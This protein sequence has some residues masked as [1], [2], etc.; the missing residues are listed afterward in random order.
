MKIKVNYFLLALF[1]VYSLPV[2]SNDGLKQGLYFCSFEV[3]K[4]KRTCLDLTPEKPLVF[5]QGFS[6][7]F[8]LNLRN[9]S[10]TFG[11]VFRIVCNDTLNVDLLSNM[12]SDITSETSTFSLIIKNRNVI[13]YKKLEI[14]NT[15]ENIWIKIQFVFD[16]VA[17][18]ISLSLNGIK[19]EAPYTLAGLNHFNVYFG[20]NTHG[21][22]STTDIAPMT[23]KDIRLFNEKKETVR[24]WKLGKH[25]SDT[26]Y[27][28][29]VPDRATTHNPVWEIDRH[30]KWEKRGTVAFA[31]QN[32]QIAFDRN[33]SRFFFGGD[34]RILVFDLNQQKVDTIEVLAGL[35]F[36]IDLSNHLVYDPNRRVLLSYDFGN[37]RL[38]TFDFSTCRWNN[39]D[40]A[41]I[42]PRYSH[43]SQLFI[44]ADSLL[45]AFGGYGYHR[46]NSRFFKCRVI[47]NVWDMADLSQT[48]PPRYLGSMGSLDD[49][50]ML[51]FSGFGNESGRQEEFPK[52]YYDLYSINIENFDVKKIWELSNPAEHFTN[53]NSMVIDK[54]R[55]KFYALAYSNKRYESIIKLH[56]YS[57]DKPEYRIA[58]DSIPY[59]FNDVESYCN[60]FQSSDSSELFA[61]TSSVKNNFSEI[62]IYAIA[63]PALNP[64]ETIQYP[65]SQSGRW[66]LSLLVIPAALIAIFILFWKKRHKRS[67]SLE[68]ES[69][70]LYEESHEKELTS[71]NGSFFEERKHSYIRLLGKFQIINRTG[72]E[73]AKNF[74]PT[75]TQ[76][77]LLLLMSTIKNGQGITPQELRKIL[78]FDKDDESAR[79]NRNV[80][81][82]KLRSILKPFEEVAIK[83][84][85]GYFSIQFEKTVFCDYERALILINALKTNNS[86]NKNL[87]TELV[88]IALTGTLLPLIQQLEWI[89][90]YQSDYANQLIECLL[91]YSKHSEV[92]QDLFLL[93]KIADVIL[94]HDNTDEDAIQQKC[95]A[96]FHLGRKKQALQVFNKF[97]A[98][99]ENLLGSKHHLIFEELVKPF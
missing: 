32:Y 99:Y 30:A 18:C 46:Y 79:N 29:C 16:P 69:N 77:F 68:L 67:S 80:Y 8:D 6:M 50:T 75:T 3:N 82:N 88:D 23:V 42:M 86:N 34:K 39:D 44:A 36:N 5:R 85:N 84:K 31:G 43:H 2:K 90:P 96:L 81:I 78:W 22:F 13:Q 55:R 58:G 89:D 61:L 62:T 49:H 27:D 64:E 33:E 35:P 56:E 83:N 10:Q 19:K 87:L 38:A 60:L 93:S 63:F 12:A 41:A 20:G 91:R 28:E 70:E 48:I 71:V 47:E 9:Y 52:S 98:D 97:T 76:L 66:S 11:Y 73:I 94:L 54:N 53:S 51:Y 15:I 21:I 45:V 24:Y 72:D 26:V 17:N 40:N 65:P 57:L 14:G 4:D 59:F 7:E 37:R 1:L 92:K 95:Y 25:L 74:T